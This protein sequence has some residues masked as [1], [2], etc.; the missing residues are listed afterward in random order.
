M[1]DALAQTRAAKGEEQPYDDM[2]D[3]DLR[4]G[5]FYVMTP[6]LHCHRD[7]LNE[8]TP[9][10]LVIR[11]SFESGSTSSCEVISEGMSVSVWVARA[12][13]PGGHTSWCNPT[14]GRE[15]PSSQLSDEMRHTCYL[16]VTPLIVP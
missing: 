9:T 15:L 4:H 1:R 13:R 5:L 16:L 11:Q 8:M 7:M 2:W 3:I 14:S 10:F 12:M 6:P